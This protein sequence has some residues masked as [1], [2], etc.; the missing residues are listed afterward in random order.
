MVT[1]HRWINPSSLDIHGIILISGIYDL[2]P[3]VYTYANDALKLDENSASR[4]GWMK[5]FCL[6]WSRGRH[7]SPSLP[8]RGPTGI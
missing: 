1:L 8:D 2:H 6:I 7:F 4:I 5:G 3:V